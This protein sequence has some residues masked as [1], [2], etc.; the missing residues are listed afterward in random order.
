M[1]DNV[2][3]VHLRNHFF[4]EES[5][6]PKPDTC[7]GVTIAYQRVDAQTIKFAMAKCH[8]NDGFNKHVGRVKSA[9]RLNSPSQ[10]QVM[11]IPDTTPRHK[12]RDSLAE[13]YYKSIED[14]LPDARIFIF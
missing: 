2:K 9:G 10:S 8:E 1:S 4:C 5:D 3:F 6:N 11:A 13:V 14:M 12:V 7:G